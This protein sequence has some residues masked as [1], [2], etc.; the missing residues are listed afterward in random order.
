MV[1]AYVKRLKF[2]INVIIKITIINRNSIKKL[3]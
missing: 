2:N 1:P 3:I